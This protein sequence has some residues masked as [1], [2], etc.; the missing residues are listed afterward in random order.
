MLSEEK[1]TGGRNPL[2]PDERKRKRTVML[3]PDIDDAVREM[4]YNGARLMTRAVTAAVKREQ[5]RAKKE[6]AG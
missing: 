5:N 3:E 6:Q 2:P 4:G 1:G